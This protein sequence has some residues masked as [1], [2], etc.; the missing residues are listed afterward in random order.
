MKIKN[1]FITS[2]IA[3]S[4][5]GCAELSAINAKIGDVAGSVNKVLQADKQ[6]ISD[7]LISKRDVDTLYVRI[8]RNIGFKT[9]EE[10]LKCDP[11][12]DNACKWKKLSIAQGGYVHEKTP[13]VYY[14]MGDSFGKDGK[15]YVDVTIEK[16]GK[17]STVSWKV[18]GSQAF[19]NEIRSDILSAIK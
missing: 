7:Q 1:V 18:K 11:T 3:L 2:L 14:R 19:A 17:N 13:G 5:S 4:L 16:D 8:K 6:T 10:M 9:M 15:Y 12:L